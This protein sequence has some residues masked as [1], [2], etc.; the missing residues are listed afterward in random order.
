MLTALRRLAGTW[1]ARVLFVVLIFSFAIWGVGDVWRNAFRDTAVV[2]VGGEAIELEEAQ[3]AAR[4]EINR[5]A[6]QLGARFEADENIRRAVAAQAIE[7][8]IADRALRAEA[9]ALGVAT[10]EETVRDAIFAIRGLQGVDGR[11]SRVLFEQFLR[12]NEVNEPQFLALVRA[13]IARQQL[14]GAVR[15]GAAGPDALTRPLLQWQNEQRIADVAL[16][17]LAD[18]PDPPAPEEA[19]LRR[20]HENNP[21]RF[22]T[23][24][25]REA[26]VA[27]LAGESL[28]GEVAVSDAELQQAYDS[29]RAQY[30]TPERRELEQALVQDEG[31]AREIAAAWSAPG[32]DRAAI[33]AMAR[34]AGGLLLPIGLVDRAGVPVAELAEAAFGAP[35]GGVVGPV[36]SA[37][38]WHVVHVQRIEPGAVRSLD[39]VRDELRREVALERALDLAYERANRVE[40]ALAGGAT[41]AEV[42]QRYGL[43]VTDVRTDI[44]GQ[45]PDGAAVALPVPQD[46]RAELLRQL[47]ALRQGDPP[48]L[49]ET[50]QGFV[51]IE[52]KRVEPPALRPFE[53]VQEE[54]ARAWRGEQRRRAL[55]EKAAGLLGAV[56]GGAALPQAAQ[57]AGLR[58]ARLGP[59]GRTPPRENAPVPPELL[60]PLF[61]LKQGEATMVE[62]R[63]GFAVAQLVGVL[64][65]EP[66]AD[67]LGLGQVRG[68]I[69]Q[70]MAD[71]L[72]QQYSAALRRRA[73]VR[74]NPTL[75]EQV[76]QR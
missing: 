16:L 33:E 7:A 24:E 14:V 9:R 28:L 47:F 71:D 53:T 22:S 59:F 2:R 66:D 42:G 74:I 8:L 55:E 75:L 43:T 50:P 15:A 56:R 51:A 72:E 54:V 12:V 45:G 29:R 52:V 18:A 76:T 35:S 36:R 34:E 25:Y 40:D 21:D 6:R 62:T 64:V 69:E 19:Q 5:V 39:Q 46:R 11:F 27:V 73:D 44:T 57:E 32:A 23:P 48:R 41:L 20:Y 4:R 1:V 31:K 49:A 58:A 63:D 30:E 3:V 17:P 13:D 10:P 60:A 38:G 67:P 61:E 37:F 26:T 70:Q 65:P 68:R